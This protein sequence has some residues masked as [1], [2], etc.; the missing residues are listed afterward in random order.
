MKK[1]IVT[2]ILVTIA[3]VL[4]IT[5]IGMLSL[6]YSTISQMVH[7][8]YTNY[9]QSSVEVAASL[10]DGVDMEKLQS[11]EAYA[12]PYEKVLQELCYANHIEYLYIYTPS[13]QQDEIT[14]T[15]VIY[16]DNSNSLA[17]QER[18]AGTVIPYTLTA[19]E[20]QLW[21]GQ[22][23]H[24]IEEVDNQ[25]GHVLSA[26]EV[27]YTPSGE[28]M[29]LIGADV[30]VAEA[31][32]SVFSRYKTMLI[33]V[34]ASFVVVLGVLAILLKKSVLKP[35]QVVNTHMKTFVKDR[36]SGF[37]PIEVKGEDELAQMAESFNS[38]AQEMD[39]YVQ[40]IQEL[41]AEKERQAAEIQIA[42]NIQ[43]GFLPESHFEK[44]GLSLEAIMIPAG[45]VGGD[46]YDYFPLGKD[47]FG[48]VIADV[49]GK[50]ISAA[51]FMARAMS[52]VRQY[53]SLG[54][55]PSQI[56]FHANN[57]LSL[58]N[59][60]QM[61]LTLFIGIYH[62]ADHK[63]VY[64]NGG[65]NIPYLI[66]DT[67]IPLDKA[68][69][70]AVAIFE[71]EEYEEEEISLHPGDTL[72]LY[73]DGV[74]EAMN[75]S[76]ALFGTDRLE[77]NLKQEDKEQCVQR[78][79]KAVNA[80]VQDAPQSDDITMLACSIL[81]Q[82][83]LSSLKLKASLENLE[84]VQKLI[85]DHPNISQSLKNKL[86]LASEEV[87]VNICSYAYEQTP[88]EVEIEL[89][90]SDQEITLRFCDWG[91]PF[92]PRNNV[93]DIEEYDFDTQIGGLGTLL[94]FHFADKVD[95]EYKDGQ[96]QLTIY[97]KQQ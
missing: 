15:C 36:Q 52:V 13:G 80:F 75:R 14:F 37:K 86:C 89:D 32:Q 16:G 56:L 90:V 64:A 39:Q 5:D 44:N 30:S 1:S 26:Y 82:A 78:V 9:A 18:T 94:A 68:Q 57:A 25:Y 27:L 45:D 62:Q 53:A 63:L 35:V 95:Y 85:M 42:H 51:L 31:L 83:N 38:M 74:N 49:S 3:V 50:G 41:S 8:T 93:V 20:L 71:E 81:P 72:F 19:L 24:G 28:P 70:M 91:K 47:T 87:F 65:H 43:K 4:L 84:V 67:L 48:F 2:K 66:S 73:T 97:K 29:A 34:T 88:G 23:E 77:D 6:G 12:M 10:L 11:D 55:S 17:K 79:L 46:F 59:P 61:F 22:K 69:G 96:N 7:K 54:Y 92:D 58:N 40:S 33:T 60:E 21:N 76:K